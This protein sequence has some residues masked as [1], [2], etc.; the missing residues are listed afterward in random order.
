MPTISQLPPANSVSAADE[1]PISQAGVVRATSVGTFLASVQPLITLDSPGLLGRTS[2][3]SG[4]PEQVDVGMG[5][6]IVNGALV[7]TGLD[8]AAFS[9]STSLS[10]DTD[11][12]ISDQGSPM[13]MK[14]SLLRGLFS[15]G[16]NVSIDA[17]GIIS[18]GSV[19]S[20]GTANGSLPVVTALASQDLVTVSQGGSA[21]AITYGNLLGGVTIDQAQAAGAVG[22]LDEFWVAQ[23]SNVMT[24][25]KFSAAWIWITK[26][27]PSYKTPVVEI[28]VDTNLDT[29]VHNG[30]LLICSQP[31]T[32]TPLTNNMGSGFQC[33][34]INASSG[35]ITLGSLFVSSSG[36][37]TLNPWQSAILSCATYSGGSIAFA[38]MPSASTAA[39]ILP[40]QVN[41]LTTT[42][43]TSTTI[44]VSWQVPQSGGGASSYVVLY[45][46]TGTTSWT[47]SAP[48]VN[49]TSYQLAALQP[50]TSYDILVEAQNEAGSGA[51]SVI[52]TVL[53]LSIEQNSPPPAVT[54][55]VA[56][57][58]SQTSIQLGWTA[59][60]GASAASTYTVQYRQTGSSTW[61]S[62]MAGI[63]GNLVNVSGL[64]AATSYDFEINGV[65][66]SG[67]GAV[68]TVVVA[69]TQASSQSV[70]SITWNV[71]PTGTF[72]RGSGAI[73]VNAQVSPAASP[74]QFGFSQSTSVRPSI[75][76]AAILVNT[77]LWGA[78]VPTPATA[79]TWFTWG[80]G[81]DGSAPTVTSSSFVVQ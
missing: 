50:G 75:W 30:R 57:A 32:L 34:V 59:Q 47:S 51:P 7:A 81:I 13:L 42:A 12:V 68:S 55:L 64:Q 53:T 4:D 3:G 39:P 70:N 27:L 19:G 26:K 44:T 23:G 16:Q 77:N 9:P 28:T 74:V 11:L 40:G 45:R 5:V 15:A 18:S 49:V 61:T 43:L 37:L 65:N 10:S 72:V 67:A 48:I 36:S 38:S 56:N 78:Y 79:G 71:T 52:L 58:T 62:S 66:A 54:G 25:Q 2:L 73:G 20:T 14:A 60:T 8:H 41:G 29:T 69:S 31:V 24:S 80:E 46:P 6:N 35:K 17:G 22:D 76:T 63:V 1:I 21:C 33:T